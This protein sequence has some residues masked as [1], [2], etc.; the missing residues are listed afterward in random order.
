MASD[1]IPSNFF[2][3]PMMKFP[4]EDEDFDIVSQ[5]GSGLSVSE[6]EKNVF[7]EAHV[8]GLEAKDIEVS[9]DKG[10]LW[11]RGQAKEEEKG[12]KYYRRASRAFSYRV[13]VPGEID[14]KKEPQANYKNGVMKV[15]FLKSPETQP[16]KITV[17]EG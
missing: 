14:L 10:V 17:K 7:V 15:T 8:P 1:L 5:G 9:F 2:R 13:A 11:V 6:D 12:K 3:L 16:K 4:W